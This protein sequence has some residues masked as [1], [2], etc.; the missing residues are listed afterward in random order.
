MPNPTYYVAPSIFDPLD[1]A[2]AVAMVLHNPAT[3]YRLRERIAEDSVADPV[4]ALEDA[5]LLVELAKV[6]L[7]EIQ[8]RQPGVGS[9]PQI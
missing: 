7:R 2:S 3:R 6:R 5:E 8:T 4:K 9:G 1:Y